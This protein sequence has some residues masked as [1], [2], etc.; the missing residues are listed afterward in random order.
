[1]L[2]DIPSHLSFHKNRRPGWRTCAFFCLLAVA[3]F[4]IGLIPTTGVAFAKDPVQTSKAVL[5]AKN[6][7]TRSGADTQETVLNTKTVN[8]QTFR[9]R[10]TYPVDGRVYAQPLFVPHLTMNGAARDVVFVATE[11]D[12]VYAFDAG[13]IANS[14]PLWQTSF[15]SYS[16]DVTPVPLSDVSCDDLGGSEAG[17]TGTPV[18]DLKTNTLYVVAVTKEHGHF[19]SRL[20]ALDI[21]TGAERPHSPVTITATYPVNGK[22]NSAKKITFNAQHQNQRAALLLLNGVVYIAWGSYCDMPPYYG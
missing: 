8:A 3:L 5:T 7:L 11:H 9:K 1:M 13:N 10:M 4:L 12:S 6:D 21:T 20:H 14:T 22:S 19:F 16:K 17:I 18:I 2:Q 15:I